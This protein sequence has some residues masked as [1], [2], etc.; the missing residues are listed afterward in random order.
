M[1][2]LASIED[3]RGIDAVEVVVGSERQERLAGGR[4]RRRTSGKAQVLEDAAGDAAVFDEGHD[5]HGAAAT[6]ADQNVGG[7]A[8]FQERGPLDPA[9]PRRIVGTADGF[10]VYDPIVMLRNRNPAQVRAVAA[11]NVV[12]ASS[13]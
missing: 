6:W 10:T 13:R 1:V 5:V 2:E 9:G 3:E 12:V 8:T 11:G 7:E 4:A